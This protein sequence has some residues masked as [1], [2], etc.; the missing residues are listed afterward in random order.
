MTWEG[1]WLNNME[2]QRDL[3]KFLI[4]PRDELY[5]KVAV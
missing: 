3:L 2:F 1:I 5:K 4:K